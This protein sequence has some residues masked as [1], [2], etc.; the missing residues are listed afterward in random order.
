MKLASVLVCALLCS[1]CVL[2]LAY[3]NVTQPLTTDFRNTPV[4]DGVNAKGDVKEI[5]YRFVELAWDENAIGTLAKQAGFDEI[6]YA[7]LQTFSILGIWT[8]RRVRVYGEKEAP[9]E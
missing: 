1:G 6:Y 7:D 9:S 5:R 8:Q 3:T 2:G 4:V